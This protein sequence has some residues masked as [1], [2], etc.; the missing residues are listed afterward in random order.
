MTI[1][2]VDGSPG[3][4]GRKGS[5]ASSPT[6]CIPSVTVSEEVRLAASAPTKSATP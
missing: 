4:N 5:S 2:A 6:V 1:A 3:R